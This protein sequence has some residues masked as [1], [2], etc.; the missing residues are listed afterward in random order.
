MISLRTST[1][2][3][4]DCRAL[5][6]LSVAS[7]HPAKAASNNVDYLQILRSSFGFLDL[8]GLRLWRYSGSLI[9]RAKTGADVPPEGALFLL[10]SV[11]IAIGCMS[12]LFGVG[13]SAMR[14]QARR[15]C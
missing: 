4:P 3:D 1:V 11:F 5:H 14:M 15:S 12:V 10:L 7:R 9:V 8:L 2:A 13:R 6:H